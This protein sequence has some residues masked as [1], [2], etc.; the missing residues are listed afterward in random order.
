MYSR[1]A[2]LYR[3]CQY[4]RPSKRVFL[5][6]ILNPYYLDT[7]YIKKRKKMGCRNNIIKQP[8]ISAIKFNLAKKKG[9]KLFCL[10]IQFTTSDTI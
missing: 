9:E 1:E 7:V 5:P 2:D 8:F 4:S 10:K 3:V 6:T